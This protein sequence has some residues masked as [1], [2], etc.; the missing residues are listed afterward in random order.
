MKIN[1]EKKYQSKNT[2]SN[3]FLNVSHLP[4]IYISELSNGGSSFSAIT[5]FVC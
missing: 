5:F 3:R 2:L 4:K 1:I